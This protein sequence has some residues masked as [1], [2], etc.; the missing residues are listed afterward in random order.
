MKKTFN[1]F[2]K[3]AIAEGISFIS[4]SWHC[5]ATE[6]FCRHTHRSYHCWF[7]TWHFI[8]CFHGSGLEVKMNLKKNIKWYAGCFLAAILPFGTFVLDQTIKEGATARRVKFLFV[9]FLVI[10]LLHQ[11]KRRYSCNLQIIHGNL[12]SV[13]PDRVAPSKY[14]ETL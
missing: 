3:I 1:W 9:C 10:L 7:N 5:H 11:R 12:R 4:S 8:Y 2:R 13:S 14:S 6:I